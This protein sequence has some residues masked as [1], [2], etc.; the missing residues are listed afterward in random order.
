MLGWHLRCAT[1]IPVL[2][3]MVRNKGCPVS[4]E[5]T[6]NAFRELIQE[7]PCFNEAMAL[8][9]KGREIKILLDGQHECALFY[10]QSAAQ[11]EYRKAQNA[12]I[13]FHV[14]T[15]AVRSLAGNRPMN[16]A[17]FGIAV[18]K[19][20]LAG[21]AKVHVISG[22][23]SVMGGGYFKIIKSAGPEFMGYLAQHGFKNIAKLQ[24][25]ISSLRK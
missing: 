12:D 16:M 21:N 2:R 14:H 11:L 24:G 3:L 4:Y 22:M 17:Q 9:K 25:L 1:T 7:Q 19:Q 10:S 6:Y 18:V 15:E 8:L 13:E 23:M 5:T 20:I